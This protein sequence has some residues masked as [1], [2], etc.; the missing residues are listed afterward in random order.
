MM[1]MNALMLC[2]MSHLLKMALLEID[3]FYSDYVITTEFTTE[4]LKQVKDYCTK[5]LSCAM[6]ESIMISFGLLRPNEKYSKLELSESTKSSEIKIYDTNNPMEIHL[7][8]LKICIA[9]LNI[10]SL[11]PKNVFN[12]HNVN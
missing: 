1:K 7:K 4:E 2:A 9:K 8:V 6:T 11:M 12:V 3:D 5:G 10:A